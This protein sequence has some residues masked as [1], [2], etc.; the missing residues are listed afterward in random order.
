MYKNVVR[1]I[2]FILVSIIF[3]SSKAPVTAAI[4]AEN[5]FTIAPIWHRLDSSFA[6]PPYENFWQTMVSRLGGQQ[7]YIKIAMTANVNYLS[8]T[9]GPTQNWDFD[10]GF[11]DR[12]RGSEH[13]H[14]NLETYYAKAKENNVKVVL[15]LGGGPWNTWKE[16]PSIDWRQSDP[17][18]SCSQKESHLGLYLQS[19]TDANMAATYHNEGFMYNQWN[20][21][22]QIP[23]KSDEGGQPP[24]QRSLTMNMYA[25]ESEMGRLVKKNLQQ[26]VRAIW[27]DQEKRDRTIAFSM[28]ADPLQVVWG[29]TGIYDYNPASIIQFREWLMCGSYYSSTGKYKQFQHKPCLTLDDINRS[30]HTQFSSTEMIDPPRV[31]N[32]TDLWWQ[33]WTRFRQHQVLLYNWIKMGWVQEVGVPSSMITGHVGVSL[34]EP[35]YNTEYVTDADMSGGSLEGGG[36]LPFSNGYSFYGDEATNKD[37][38]LFQRVKSINTNWTV[39]EINP[40]PL[41]RDI[42]TTYEEAWRSLHELFI[43]QASIISPIAWHTNYFDGG[44]K[45]GAF[46]VRD[47]AYEDAIRDFVELYGKYPR[48]AMVWEF[49][50]K[51]TVC[52]DKTG[53]SDCSQLDHTNLEGWH[54]IA[55]KGNQLD[56]VSLENGV[57]TVKIRGTDPYFT[58]PDNLQYNAKVDARA[59]DHIVLKLKFETSSSPAVGEV[60]WRTDTSAEWDDNKKIIFEII[61]DGQFHEYKLP[62]GMIPYWKDMITQFRIDIRGNTQFIDKIV[63]FDSV[64]LIDGVFLR[65]D[66]SSGDADGNGIVNMADYYY[67]VAAANGGSIPTTVNPDVNGDGEVG[68]ADRRIII[69]ALNL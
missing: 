54:N 13:T 35:T 3:L 14:D 62:V 50:K 21:R 10:P 4:N 69:N 45:L 49:G 58:S 2:V 53:R 60:L 19:I 18:K 32:S 31:R 5:I 27:N 15:I 36:I 8:D 38:S 23:Q 59:S 12:G 68:V 28:E 65:A 39:T 47:T 9:K 64:L 52:K 11:V 7:P 33:E 57:V 26:V 24:L 67:Y 46:K 29:N 40:A 61:T 56:L 42:P 20:E 30:F 41:S 55:P 43:H 44:N 34:H 63:V 22:N 25:L 17:Y 16:C 48:G 37:N 1:T 6:L 66:R 51:S